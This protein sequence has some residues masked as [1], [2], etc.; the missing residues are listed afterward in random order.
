MKKGLII[1]V[2]VVVVGA[3][4]AGAY[5]LLKKDNT[6]T[7]QSTSTTSSQ[8]G[9]THADDQTASTTQETVKPAETSK[10][11]IQ[12][13]AYTPANITVKKGTT[14]TWTNNDSV[15]HTV[16]S[17]DDSAL[18]FDSKTLNKGQTFSTTFDKV[19][20][21]SYHCTPHPNMTGSVTVTE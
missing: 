20:S 15:G 9:T 6:K 10:V 19:G 14:V 7:A 3:G 5:V 13:F 4:A 12:N 1:V 2:I 11:V 17:D 8:S 21:F 18:S 16:T